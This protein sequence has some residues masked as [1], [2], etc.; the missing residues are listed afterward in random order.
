MKVN[1]LIHKKLVRVTGIEPT[2]QVWKTRTLA[3]VLYPQMQ[4][5]Q[6]SLGSLHESWQ[7]D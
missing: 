3:V 4:T 6:L 1:I 5:F 2:S 7:Y